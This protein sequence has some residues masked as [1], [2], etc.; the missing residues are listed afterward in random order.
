MRSASIVFARG[1]LLTGGSAGGFPSAFA[2]NGSACG[3][4][5][6]PRE[7]SVR[8][9]KACAAAARPGCGSF[10]GDKE[11]EAPLVESVANALIA[12]K[13]CIENNRRADYFPDWRPHRAA[14]WPTRLGCPS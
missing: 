14:V 7:V 3:R 8:P 2:L 10:F 12:F 5:M 1:P 11:G 9:T 6:K 13:C 4:A